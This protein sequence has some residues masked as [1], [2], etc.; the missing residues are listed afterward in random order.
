MKRLFGAVAAVLLMGQAAPAARVDA[1]GWMAGSW[2]SNENGAW[3]EEVWSPPRAG[4]LIG[5]SHTSLGGQAGEFEYMRI[6]AGADGV[7]VYLAQPGGA[8][9]VPFRLTAGDAASATFDNPGH[10]FPQRIVYRRSGDVMVATISALDGSH[11]M[12]WTYRRR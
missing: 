3:T 9:A 1:L 10:D 8:P 12:T 5:D 2:E 7:P 11:A 6:E 4:A